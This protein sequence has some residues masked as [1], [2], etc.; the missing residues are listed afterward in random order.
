MKEINLNQEYLLGIVLFLCIGAVFDIRFKKLPIV[1]L[2][3]GIIYAVIVTIIEIMRSS[4]N[5]M[6]LLITLT[7]AIVLLVLFYFTRGGIGMGDGIII[8][9]CSCSMT[10]DRYLSFLFFSFLA[11][12]AFSLVLVLT[13]K[14]SRKKEIPFVPFMLIV[15]VI[16]SI[17]ELGGGG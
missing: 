9:I 8:L 7:I 14:V 16:I 1:Y 13:K 4:Q 10:Y 11:S 2:L 6:S 12:A 17:L 15:G 5:R 3:V